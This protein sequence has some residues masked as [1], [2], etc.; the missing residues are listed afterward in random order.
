MSALD[1]EELRGDNQYRCELCRG[2]VDATRQL[3]LRAL[4]PYLCISLKRFVYD[5]RVRLANLL[6]WLAPVAVMGLEKPL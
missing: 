5:L 4:P 3:C 1:V 6:A 2:M